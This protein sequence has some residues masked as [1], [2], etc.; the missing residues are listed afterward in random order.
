M[1][2]QEK[3]PFC[4]I[5][6]RFPRALWLIASI[7]L[8]STSAWA[9]NNDRPLRIGLPQSI[10]HTQYG[11]VADWQQYL[12][13]KLHRPV[14]FVNSRKFSD[15]IVQLHT[16]KVDFAWV[17]DYPNTML[18]YQV[19]LLAV[20]L[21]KGRPFFSS[22]LIVSASNTQTTSLMQLKDTIFVFADPNSNSHIEHRYTLLKAGED[23]RRFFRKVFFTHAHRESI[24]AVTLG[25]ANAAEVDN[26]VWDAMAK[27]HPELAAQTRI[28]AKSHEFGAPPLVANHFV[29][30]EEFADMQ[31]V[32]I[33]MAQNPEG[34]KLLKRMN[35]DGF[36]PGEAKLY[37]S[38]V[39]M[40][41]ELGEE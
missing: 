28:V 3:L 35:L 31:S 17:T 15:S 25:L 26:F 33:G 20:P 7:L 38:L 23:P 10:F 18:R 12:Q 6:N 9:M 36:I 14:E 16:E 19:R 11:L 30:K 41:K 13:T 2:L 40:K 22:Y 21:Y 24:E 5:A 32:L 4:N 1:T 27:G 37:D 39:Q 29:S 8:F 34:M